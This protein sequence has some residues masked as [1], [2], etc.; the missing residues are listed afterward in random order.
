MENAYCFDIT[1][2]MDVKHFTG[3]YDEAEDFIIQ[4]ILKNRTEKMDVVELEYGY[5]RVN[6]EIDFEEGK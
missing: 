1:V 6:S 5:K 3:G 4:W 2:E